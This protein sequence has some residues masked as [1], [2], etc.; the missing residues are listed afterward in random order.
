MN[1]GAAMGGP[2]LQALHVE[3]L[4]CR[5]KASRSILTPASRSSEGRKD[6]VS[7]SPSAL[8]GSP[9]QE[10]LPNDVRR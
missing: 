1:Q 10:C 3:V 4:K 2:T 6:T 7:P 5:R 8:K 9:F